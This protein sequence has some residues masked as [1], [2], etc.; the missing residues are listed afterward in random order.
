MQTSLQREQKSLLKRDLTRD[1]ERYTSALRQ[2]VV[3]H[4]TRWKKQGKCIQRRARP[5]IEV[6]RMFV[7]FGW[8][9]V[10]LCEKIC[11]LVGYDTERSLLWRLRPGGACEKEFLEMKY[12]SEKCLRECASSQH[13]IFKPT[14][15]TVD[16]TLLKPGKTKGWYIISLL[17]RAVCMIRKVF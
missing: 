3:S 12:A 14:Y 10:D 1:R 13:V 8:H 9:F 6:D 7:S 11:H 2:S 4:K 16:L 5:F 15:G 17:W